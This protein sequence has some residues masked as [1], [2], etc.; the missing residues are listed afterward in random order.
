MDRDYSGIGEEGLNE[1][2]TLDAYSPSE[3]V[4]VTNALWRR[5]YGHDVID[6]IKDDQGRLE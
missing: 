6:P 1:L 2:A 4:M 3:L 5:V